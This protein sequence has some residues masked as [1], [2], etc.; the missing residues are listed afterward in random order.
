M[1]TFSVQLFFYQPMAIR[2]QWLVR[3]YSSRY[4]F[5]HALYEIKINLNVM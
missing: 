5:S 4:I 3:D 1:H 2:E